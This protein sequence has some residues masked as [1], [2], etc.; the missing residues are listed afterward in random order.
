[1][2]KQTQ[3]FRKMQ[4]TCNNPQ[5]KG[6]TP[7]KIKEIMQRWK[8]EY[9]CFCYETGENGTYH[10]HLYI[11]FVNPQSWE[12][13][14]KAF[15][16]A[17]IEPA[18]GTSQENRD[19]IRKEGTYKVSEKAATNHLDTFYESGTCPTDGP[20]YQGHRT[21]LEKI[22][23]MLKNGL[24]PSQILDSLPFSYHRYERD[25]RAKFFALRSKKTPPK[26]EIRSYGM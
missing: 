20:D 15:A 23:D 16:N 13:I 19:Y 11:K 10:F 17:H 8:T 6:L 9:F 1:M 12:T 7:D 18:K 14:S 25:I 21:D 26:R 4:I 3:K 24:N 22:D 2:N 5:E